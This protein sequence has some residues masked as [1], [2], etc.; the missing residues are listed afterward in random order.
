[1]AGEGPEAV[2]RQPDGCTPRPRGSR[3]RGSRQA[4]VTISSTLGDHRRRRA[5]LSARVGEHPCRPSPSAVALENL[6]LK[7]SALIEFVPLSRTRRWV[8]PGSGKAQ[9]EPH[10]RRDPSSPRDRPDGSR[11]R[12]RATNERRLLTVD[13]CSIHA[14]R[15]RIFGVP[16]AAHWRPVVANAPLGPM[17]AFGAVACRVLSRV[18]CLRLSKVVGRQVDAC[19]PRETCSIR[20]S[21]RAKSCSA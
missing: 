2:V 21:A 7:P 8:Q 16:A 11:R 12:F 5:R 1:M 10:A 19:G 9:D 20:L 3:N 6:E 18:K 13:T 17:P 14:E 15:L 4:R